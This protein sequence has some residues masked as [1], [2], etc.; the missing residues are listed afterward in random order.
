VRRQL[1]HPYERVFKYSRQRSVN[2]V[3]DVFNRDPISEY[4]SVLKVWGAGRL[5][6]VDADQVEV[7]PQLLQQKVKVQLHLA[8]GKQRYPN[9]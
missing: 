6:G 4:D 3:A 1:A 7:L 5:L 9:Q 2:G 8:T